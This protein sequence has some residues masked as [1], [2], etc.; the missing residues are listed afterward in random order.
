VNRKECDLFVYT[1]TLTSDIALQSNSWSEISKRNP[2]DMTE[3]LDFIHG[4][5]LCSLSFSCCLFYVYLE[6]KQQKSLTTLMLV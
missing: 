5:H 1:S 2:T 4:L 3:V 6:T